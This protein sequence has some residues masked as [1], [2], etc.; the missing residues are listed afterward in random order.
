MP[1]VRQSPL[2]A[3]VT[4]AGVL[5]GH[6]HDQ[7]LDLLGDTRSAKRSSRLAPVKL[8]GDQALIPA[9]EGI[10]RH[11]SCH[12]FEALAAE[13][14]GQR[15]ETATFGVRQAQPAATEL[16]FEDAIFL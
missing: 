15:G 13:G 7:L 9:H 2:D 6:A 12:L 14:M 5:L 3:T 8:L 1:Q 16:G 4:P 11:E 10:G